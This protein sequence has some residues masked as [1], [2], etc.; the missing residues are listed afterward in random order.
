MSDF[1][2][3]MQEIRFQLRLRPSAPDPTGELTVPPAP[4]AVFKG[5][6]F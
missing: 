2:A 6:Y 3:K 1:N 5:A 4:L